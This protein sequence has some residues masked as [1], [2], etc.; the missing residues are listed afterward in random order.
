MLAEHRAV[1]RVHLAQ[2]HVVAPQ[3]GEVAQHLPFH[4][5]NRV[6]PEQWRE[7]I[8]ARQRGVAG[9]MIG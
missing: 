7:R 3:A 4:Q 5:D 6:T 9:R 8:A 1:V 2:Q